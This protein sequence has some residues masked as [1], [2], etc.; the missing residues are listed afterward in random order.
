MPPRSALPSFAPDDGMAPRSDRRAGPQ[1]RRALFRQVVSV[2]RDAQAWPTGLKQRLR[3]V[4]S[5]R[6]PADRAARQRARAL[7]R[8]G[9]DPRPVA[10]GCKAAGGGRL[11][12]GA[13][14]GGRPVRGG[15]S[16]PA[17]RKARRRVPGRATAPC[18]ICTRSSAR[19][20]APP[21]RARSRRAFAGW[22]GERVNAWRQKS[23]SVRCVCGPYRSARRRSCRPLLARRG[24]RMCRGANC[25]CSRHRIRRR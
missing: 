23:H 25:R 20:I 8:P 10:R 24:R 1:R 11:R 22:P 19:G 9:D 3:G 21:R 15:Q 17:R 5:A 6:R 16:A 7:R 14:A 4:T 12:A 13:R 2:V 18:T